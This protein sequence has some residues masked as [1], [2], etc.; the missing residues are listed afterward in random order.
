MINGSAANETFY[1]ET[2]ADYQA[3]LGAGAE[4]LAGGTEIVVSRA[5]GA[6]A[7]VVIAELTDIDDI[8]VNGLGG[9]DNYVISGD[10]VGTDLDPSTIMINGGDDADI[11]DASGITSGHRVVFSGNDGDDTFTSG[12]GD[13]VFDGGAGDDTYVADGVRSNFH[14]EID[15]NGTITVTDEVGDNGTDTVE[16]NVEFLK[17]DDHV[18]DLT[19]P[20][21]LFNAADG[22]V[23][24]YATLQA[25]HDDASDGYRINIAGTITNTSLTITEENLRIEGQ[26]DDTGNTFTLGSG[27]TALTLLGD[28][29]FDIIGNNLANVINGNAGANNIRG[30]KGN[31]TIDGGAGNDTFLVSG[32]SEGRDTYN[33]GTGTDT[34]KALTNNT[35]IGILGDFSHAANSIEEI[36]ANGKSSIDVLGDNGANNWD[37]TDVK[38]TGD[39][40][41]TS[42]D[43]N[44]VVT[45][46]NVS[47]TT[48][49]GGKGNDTLNGS[50]TDTTYLVS[51]TNEGHDT[52]NGGEGTDTIKA[53]SNNTDIGILGDFSHAANSIEEIDANG[54]SSID[55]LGDNGAN[56]WDF[57]DVELIGDLTI[58]SRD[59]NDVVTASDVSNT[60]IRGGKGNDTLNGSS[61]DTTY[62]VSGTN[63][64]H[65]TYNG[66][67]GTDTIKALTNNTD[68]G[69]LGDFSHA[70]NSIEE[71]DANGKSSIDVLGDNGAN[72][73]DFTDVEL[74]GDLTINS[75]DGNDVVTASN[76]SNTTIRGGKGN[77]TLN[78]S[79][80]DTTYLVSGTNEGH[81]TYNGG[82][83][84]DTIKALSNNTDIGILGDFSHAANSIE[85]ID[86]NGKS[87]IEVLGD[88]GANNWD[89]TDVELT[90]DL[91][92]NSRDGNDVVTASD[93]SNTTIR[94]G[95]GNDTLNGSSTDT[96]YLVS[97]TNEGHDTYN[98]GTGTDTIKALS[99]NTDI[100]ILGDF[101]HAANSIEEIDA[102]GKSNVEVLGTTGNNNLDFRDVQLI[103]GIEIDAASGDDTVTT[104]QGSD[105][106]CRLSR[107]KGHRHA[108]H[109]PNARS[110]GGCDPNR[111]DRCLGAGRRFQWR[112]ECRRLVIRG[113]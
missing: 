3:R 87:S 41:I 6:G 111:T 32:T 28:A 60:T 113:V 68:I 27:V 100:G 80:T 89:F 71:I 52:Y 54:K 7:S 78:G 88:N 105:R 45:A 21:H 38:L 26:A 102:N 110:G 9:T 74:T 31:D 66:G 62:L 112:G 1:I 63:E 70:A 94:G 91:T 84:T 86:A 64:G 61:T 81:D 97:G 92:I 4:T 16:N 33:G 93:V 15:A 69:I 76:V 58:N 99:N 44:D 25:A 106:P 77:D 30:G 109:L 46:S 79:S 11:V 36:D 20:V 59:G 96:T 95:K 34:I 83:G 90:G 40:T 22:L 49:R 67:T 37:F 23:G 107:R 2:V 12:A 10:F 72:N 57:T 35:D 19:Q 39:L 103:N 50:S 17:F 8:D 24:T 75:R 101:S 42:G 5:E 43:G 82:T 18:F 65:D 108:T 13:D 29:P 85:E 56:N 14:I 48:I 55:V 47:N 98:G 104:S 51:G 53:L 73:W